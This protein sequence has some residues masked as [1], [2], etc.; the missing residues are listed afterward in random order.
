LNICSFFAPVDFVFGQIFLVVVGFVVFYL[1][2]YAFT[3]RQF[4]LFLGL[5]NGILLGMLF[6][7]AVLA[8]LAQVRKY[9]S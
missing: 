2:P 6:G 3:F 8:S 5:L 4:G 9:S 7:L 1:I